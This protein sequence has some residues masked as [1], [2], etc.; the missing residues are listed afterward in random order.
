[1]LDRLTDYAIGSPKN[2]TCS[3]SIPISVTYSKIY[4]YNSDVDHPLQKY[5]FYLKNVKIIEKNPKSIKIVLS[6]SKSDK[7]FIEYIDKLDAHIFRILQMRNQSHKNIKKSYSEKEFHPP[8]FVLNTE[9]ATIFDADLMQE[10]KNNMMQYLV[11]RDNNVDST[12]IY[13]P[14]TLDY[15]CMNEFTVSIIIELSDIIMNDTDYWVNYSVKQMKIKKNPITSSI[16]DIIDAAEKDHNYQINENYDINNITNHVSNHNHISNHTNHITAN[17]HGINQQNHLNKPKKQPHLPNLTN[18]PL[19]NSQID[20]RFLITADDLK[21]QLKKIGE[22]KTENFMQEKMDIVLK[23]MEAFKQKKQQMSDDI[24][25]F[26][27]VKEILP[28]PDND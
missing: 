27:Y 10:N 8:I 22:K 25:K 20:Y 18:Q 2:I 3:D 6:N 4:F 15:D 5:W 14:N 17:T 11:N 9:K 16:F 23:E 12:K 24:E 13:R 26:N 1:M 19:N 7:K 28:E 21:S